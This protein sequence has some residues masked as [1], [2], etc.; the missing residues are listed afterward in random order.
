HLGGLVKQRPSAPKEV[1]DLDEPLLPFGLSN[2]FRAA[3]EFIAFLQSQLVNSLPV[4]LGRF[5]GDVPLGFNP[6]EILASAVAGGRQHFADFDTAV[7]ADGNG[8][9]ARILGSSLAAAFGA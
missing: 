4:L 3:A 8:A 6:A 5:A 1:L 7:A 2:Q 9:A